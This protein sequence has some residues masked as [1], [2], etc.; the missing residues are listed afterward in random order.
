M[1]VLSSQSLCL[2]C[3]LYGNEHSMETPEAL[4]NGELLIKLVMMKMPFGK[5]KGTVLCDLPM[6]YLEWFAAKGFPKGQMGML[7]ATIFEV[8]LNGL[9]HLL[10]PIKKSTTRSR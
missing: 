5:Y 7:L 2:D 6:Y 9:T 1:R 8:K 4:P 3:Y 10:D